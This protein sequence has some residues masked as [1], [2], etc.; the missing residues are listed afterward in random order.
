MKALTLKNGGQQ[1]SE[2]SH[3]MR[4]PYCTIVIVAALAI[5][6]C[7][8]NDQPSAAPKNA[9]NLG[10]IEFTSKVPQDFSLGDGKGCTLTAEPLP[11]CIG[12]HVTVVTTNSDG[13]ISRSESQITTSAGRQCAIGVGENQPMISFT[14]MLKLQ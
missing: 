13:T 8:K 12:V 2:L 11:G 5:A 1:G 9:K 4:I 3:P 7:S 14:P 6:G 10:T